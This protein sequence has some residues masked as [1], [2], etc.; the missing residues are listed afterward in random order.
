MTEPASPLPSYPSP[1]TIGQILDRIFRLFR[2]QIRLFLKIASL[3]AAAMVVMYGIIFGTMFMVA[4][5]P[6][7]GQTPPDPFKAMTVLLPVSFL[8]G[9]AFI[10]LYAIFEAAGTHAALQANLGS[11]VTFREAYAVAFQNAGRCLRLMLLRVLWIGLPALGCF[12][13]IGALM[14]PLFRDSKPA[15]DAVLVWLPILF[16]MYFGSFVYAIIMGLR[17]SLALPACLSENL[18]ARTALQRTVALTRKAKGRIFV[19]V[20]VVYA[21]GYAVVLVF[22]FAGFVLAIL[23]MFLAS[24]LHLPAVVGFIGF[25]IVGLCMVA[26]MFV[27][28]AALVAGFTLALAVLYH[29]QRLRIDGVPAGEPA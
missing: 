18:T 6:R 11:P 2:A 26:A 25:G 8:A 17:L 13:L 12:G 29:D 3:P 7:P 4:G 19:V 15:P 24:G 9:L 27:Y 1:L 22:E 28:I 14:M 21:L 20:L 5:F 23:G 16:L 10:I